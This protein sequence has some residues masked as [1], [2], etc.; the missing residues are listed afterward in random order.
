MIMPPVAFSDEDDPVRP[1]VAAA[2]APLFAGTLDRAGPPEPTRLLDVALAAILAAA[3]FWYGSRV[4][5]LAA[6][7]VS[8]GAATCRGM[9]ADEKQDAAPSHGVQRGDAYAAIVRKGQRAGC[10]VEKKQKMTPIRV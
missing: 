4:D 1:S 3:S 5:V 7:D 2:P 9:A 10:S 8:V 6:D